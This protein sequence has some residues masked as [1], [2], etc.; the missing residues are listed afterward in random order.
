MIGISMS[1]LW[2][3]G[4]DFDVLAGVESGEYECQ[5]RGSV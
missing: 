2:P 5:I 1:N 4:H 3:A